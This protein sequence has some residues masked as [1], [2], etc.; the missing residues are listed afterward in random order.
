M[1][2]SISTPTDVVNISLARLGVKKRIGN[3][4]DGSPQALKALDVY[5]QTRDAVLRETDWNFSQKIAAAVAAPGSTAP[6][7]LY[8]FVYTYPTDCIKVRNMYAASYLTDTNNPVPILWSIGD[9]PT[10]GTVIWSNAQT[11]TL[12]YTAR[13]TTITQWEPLFVEAF[14]AALSRRLAPVLASLDLVKIESDD[15]KVSTELGDMTVG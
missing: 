14:A 10:N 5:A 12:I 6:T 3:L 13:V 4:Y 1:T 7:P 11:A 8:A 9:D 2:V 15:E